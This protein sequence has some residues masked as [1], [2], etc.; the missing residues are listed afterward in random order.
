M[1]FKIVLGLPQTAHP[2]L[3]LSGM[4]DGIV[5]A[6]RYPGKCVRLTDGDGSKHAANRHTIRRR[7]CFQYLACQTDVNVFRK[8]TQTP[9]WTS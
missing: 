9:P 6:C 5:P 8:T 3:P 7:Y 4:R 2:D 1:L